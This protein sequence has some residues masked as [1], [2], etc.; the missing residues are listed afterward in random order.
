MADL[1]AFAPAKINLSLA[2]TGRREDGYHLMDSLVIFADLSDQITLR[3]AHEDTLS[4]SGPFAEKLHSSSVDDNIIMQAVHA[5]RLASGWSQQFSISLLKN[6]PVAAGIGG[7]SSNAAATLRALNTL[8]PTPLSEKKLFELGLGLGADVPVCLKSNNHH[9]WRMRG[10]GEVLDHLDY[11]LSSS[12]GL[13]LLNPGI[14]VPTGAIFQSLR[15][16]S[17]LDGFQKENP[18]PHILDDET[19]RTWLDDGNSLTA[20]ALYL[21]QKI[22]E[23]LGLLSDL[24]DRRGFIT[25]GMS[26]SGATVFALFRSK[27]LAVEAA[28]NLET[29]FWFWAG[30][31][32]NAE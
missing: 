8:C 28:Q 19:F 21:H 7:G 6:I 22:E 20:P 23:A 2:I 29:S 14:S 13:I 30:G 17:T 25:S 16:R 31:I 15:E 1:T 27:A 11:P 26:G 32:F 24:S 3:F 12:L 18:H 4:V 5:Y 9:L 10:I